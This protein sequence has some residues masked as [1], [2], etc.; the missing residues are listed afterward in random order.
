MKRYFKYFLFVLFFVLGGFLVACDKNSNNNDNN[1]DNTN[2]DNTQDTPSDVVENVYS[3]DFSIDEEK[4]SYEAKVSESENE[5]Q[6]KVFLKHNDKY[7]ENYDLTSTLEKGYTSI[8]YR[9][10]LFN[11]VGDKLELGDYQHADIPLFSYEMICGTYNALPEYSEEMGDLVLN[12][13]GTGTFMD[14]ALKYYPLVSIHGG[15]VI[16]DQYNNGLIVTLEYSSKTF[17]TSRGTLDINFKGAENMDVYY[18]IMLSN[19]SS[20]FGKNY[21][22]GNS[23][24]FLDD[25][26][27]MNGDYNLIG[28]Y[29]KN[30]EK[31]TLTVGDDS[32]E[33]ILNENNYTF[34]L[35]IE[36]EYKVGD[37]CVVLYKNGEAYVNTY[38]LTGRFEVAKNAI[39]MNKPVVY[40]YDSDTTYIYDELLNVELVINGNSYTDFS[41]LKKYDYIH[42]DYDP[43]YSLAINSDSTG[44]YLYET[45]SYNDYKLYCSYHE[46]QKISD[47]IYCDDERYYFIIGDKFSFTYKEYFEDFA[48]A[49]NCN[50]IEYNIYNMDSVY[51]MDSYNSNMDNIIN[52][53]ICEF[54]ID[55][56]YYAAF[57][58]G[59]KVNENVE[60]GNYDV[61]HFFGGEIIGIS[62]DTV[63]YEENNVVAAVGKIKKYTVVKYDMQAN[64]TVNVDFD[65]SYL[66]IKN[67]SKYY[68]F[69]SGRI[70][71][72]FDSEQYSGF[73]GFEVIRKSKIT[74][75]I[76]YDSEYYPVII[77]AKNKLVYTIPKAHN[78]ESFF[79]CC[80]Q[81]FYN[82]GNIYVYEAYTYEDVPVMDRLIA[83]KYQDDNE[84][85]TG[86]ISITKT[87][88]YNVYTYGDVLDY[89]A[90]SD[91]TFVERFKFDNVTTPGKDVRSFEFDIFKDEND[92]LFAVLLGYTIEEYDE[93][94]NPYPP[95][96][97][98]YIMDFGVYSNTDN[99]YTVKSVYK[100][101]TYII[102]IELGN[103]N[104]VVEYDE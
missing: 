41:K 50:A 12:A 74:N 69:D 63:L 93:T 14:I 16:V 82:V 99:V 2:G 19:S 23:L 71:Y 36:K 67:D 38:N 91:F 58:L 53:T 49:T 79:S 3:Y 1:N 15:I 78:A 70:A 8:P 55:D 97:T 21:F 7:V 25:Y 44:L 68:L 92:N 61:H 103:N 17:F 80:N 34:D 98:L 46:C 77:N 96:F 9:G 83:Y 13:D 6:Y 52:S 32:S 104:L 64:D 90:L 35:E 40:C 33:I 75:D 95:L 102:T 51:Q 47:G 85:K 45:A 76:L 72:I 30:N 20:Y 101:M 56:L 4:F 26:F 60:E 10:M 65:D 100:N 11:I 29:T 57:I 88:C 81:L 5:I 31:V 59:E 86:F 43:N 94:D 37:K 24:F 54:I 18:D 87:G 27:Y 62:N 42:T 84:E 66:T 22:S 89:S 28:K 48:P 39:E 73:K